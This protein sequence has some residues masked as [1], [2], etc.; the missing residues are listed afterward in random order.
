MEDGSV[1]KEKTNFFDGLNK[2]NGLLTKNVF[3]EES[4]RFVMDKYNLGSF[5]LKR[6]FSYMY[7]YPWIITYLN[8]YMNYLGIG[9]C[10]L[11]EFIKSYR[12]ILACNGVLDSRS[13]YYLKSSDKKDDLQ[14]K[15]ISLLDR[16]F[17]EIYKLNFSYKELLFYYDLYLNG[18][19][20]NQEI[21]EIDMLLNNNSKTINLPDF[22]PQK[23][24]D[25]PIPVSKLIK[26]F[27]ESS[28]GVDFV[29][30]EIYKKKI[31]LCKECQYFGREI[32]PFDGNIDNINNIDV[33]LVN[34]NPDLNDLREKRT[35]KENSIVRQN[36]ALFPK[37]V[38]WLLVNL[39]PCSF[40]SKS[41]LGKN[42]D[43]IKDHLNG[44]NRV[45]LD[46]INN[47][48]KPKITI[49]IG[50][51]AASAFLPAAEFEESLGNLVHDRY[52]SVLHPNSMRQTKAQIRGKKYWENV[53]ELVENLQQ[54]E[55]LPK[56]AAVKEDRA[57]PKPE[58]SEPVAI[59][60]VKKKDKLLLLDVKEIEDG[61]SVLLVFTDEDGNKHYDKRR[62]ATSGYIKESNFKEC[63][64]LT[65]SVDI[66][67]TMTKM[68]KLKLNKLL[69]EK[70]AK[71]K[72]N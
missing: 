54:K 62:N 25:R 2:F 30:N 48:L 67:F 39:S 17:S 27:T 13:F 28:R 43:E 9:S 55:I 61:K 31:E 19:I 32:V 33:L 65:D 71:L 37:D 72:G 35:F 63:S 6:L 10:G 5:M 1:I 66:E 59:E 64:I 42:T 70:M 57:I 58:N 7:N 47:N 49:L 50:Q 8:K 4:M 34:L 11:I 44:C 45:V 24:N 36:I 38:K 14:M 15:I 20:T 21:Y 3:D 12:Y 52:V 53:Q 41:E 29:N 60:K 23:S 16:Y 22:Q 56:P 69:R 40:K 26:R 68:E 18:V 51:E 46:F